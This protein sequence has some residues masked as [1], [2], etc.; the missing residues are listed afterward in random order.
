[1]S[2]C[3]ATLLPRVTGVPVLVQSESSMEFL[4]HPELAQAFVL[5]SAL[6][7]GHPRKEGGVPQKVPSWGVCSFWHFQLP[8]LRRKDASVTSYQSD[9]F[10][11]NEGE[12]DS[13]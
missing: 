1:M 4:H 10:V 6:Q 3:P 2:V 13:A 11:P 12:M 7:K 8:R 9:L 5:S